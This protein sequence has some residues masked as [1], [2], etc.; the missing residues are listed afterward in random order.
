MLE[1]SMRPS[2][3]PLTASHVLKRKSQVSTDCTI[4][5]TVSLNYYRL[6]SLSTFNMSI[7]SVPTAPRAMLPKASGDSTASLSSL[8][9]IFATASKEVYPRLALFEALAQFKDEHQP[10]APSSDDVV[11]ARR[12]F[13]DSFAYLCDVQKGGQTVTA[14]GLQKL[15]YSNVLWL[16]AN[17]GIRS[18]VKTYAESV[19]S[20]LLSVDPSTQRIVEDAVFH[21]AVEKCNSRIVTYKDDM[22]KYARNCRMQLRRETQNEAGEVSHISIL[23]CRGQTIADL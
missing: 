18:D 17:E 4:W 21:F 19:L 5:L 6:S 12:A 13:L 8:E 1:A 15:P 16:A 3:E 11:E 7:I 9:Q 20:K 14:A 22:Q 2:H 23:S 10:R